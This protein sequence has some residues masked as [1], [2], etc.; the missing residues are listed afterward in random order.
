[1]YTIV[2]FLCFYCINYMLTHSNRFLLF[3]KSISS[4]KPISMKSYHEF[5]NH[6]LN[7]ISTMC[8]LYLYSTS[9]TIQYNTENRVHY[10]DENIVYA[11]HIYNGN[12]FLE[13]LQFHYFK[14]NYDQYIHHILTIS[15]YAL[16]LYQKSYI[17]YIH[18]LGFTGVSNIPLKLIQILKTLHIKKSKY[19]NY[20][21]ICLLISFFIFRVLN[22]T[23]ILC[24]IFKD[25]NHLISE[26]G[27][28]SFIFARKVVLILY[29]LQI[30]WLIHIF[31]LLTK[32][33]KES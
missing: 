30:K 1:M 12:S 9:L 18:L 32:N 5:I 25:S 21:G 14:I 2:S 3:F 15:V 13:L 10:Y 19:K 23:Y 27:N 4:N 33:I 16:A 20:L 31:H 17:Y 22:F 8:C 11:L 24:L 7:I 28:L 6:V 26:Y 29:A